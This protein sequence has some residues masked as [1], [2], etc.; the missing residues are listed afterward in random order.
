MTFLRARQSLACVLMIF[1]TAVL[2]Q[3]SGTNPASG[4]PLVA[5][6]K[7]LALRDAIL[8][9][10]RGN[11][12]LKGFAFSLRAQ[13][14]R[15]DA[16]GL[17]PQPEV[18]A[19]LE[20][21]FGSG[22][23][24]WL[25]SAE[26]TFAISQVVELGNK[27]NLRVDVARSGSS[28]IEIERKAAQLDVL[29]EVSRRFIQ[30]VANQQQL[31]LAREGADLAKQIVDAVKQRV[32]AARSPEAELR[33]A[34][35]ELIRATIE[36]RHVERQLEISRAKLAAMWGQPEAVFG[37][38]QADLLSLPALQDFEKLL[39]RLEKN[40]DLARFA[41]EAR[42]RDAE[43]RLAQSRRTPDIQLS[44]GVRRLQDSRDQAL[45]AGFSMP[46][47]S[48][49]TAA[50]AIAEARALRDRVDADG[51]AHRIKLRTQLY[52]LHQELRHAVDEARALQNE[53]IPELDKALEETR[54]AYER[55]RYSYLDLIDGQRAF[56]EVKRALLDNATNAQI[57][58]TEIE[59]L[60]GEPL[61]EPNP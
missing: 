54:Y 28:T 34:N 35:V 36:Q 23:A 47:Y 12:D 9:A 32:D 25:S 10:L 44:L 8:A 52:E 61:A 38:A 55:G 15:T 43:L 18:S 27:R 60:T 37:P 3:Q 19:E 5:V 17:K 56:L 26:L 50:P 42:V 1:S 59:R 48:K 49:E 31:D 7:P 33:R 29:A 39:S 57:L 53:L 46:L 20:N 41:S 22:S 14:A 24:S 30:V 40:P 11:P 4:A 45:V 21:V 2:A 16:A 6:D 58:Q 51:D 13:E